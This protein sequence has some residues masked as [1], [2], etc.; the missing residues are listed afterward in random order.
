MS[1]FFVLTTL[2]TIERYCRR[3][4]SVSP[5]LRDLVR[6]S[7]AEL[8]ETVSSSVNLPVTTDSV[9]SVSRPTAGQM[10]N[11]VIPFKGNNSAMYSDI[12]EMEFTSD[13]NDSKRKRQL[14]D[15]DGFVHPGKNKTARAGQ[16]TTPKGPEIKLSNPFE[17]LRKET[18]QAGLSKQALPPQQPKSKRMPPIVVKLQKVTSACL[19]VIKGQASDLVTFEYNSNGLK[20]RTA[21]NADHNNIMNFLK[22]RGVEFYSLNPNPMQQVRFLLRGLPPRMENHEIIDGERS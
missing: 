7:R 11:P 2:R 22:N 18:C 14:P 13:A 8:L 21:T 3:P 20:V 17:P 6:I 4:R 5:R 9:C 12:E 19:I 16:L 10:S 15:E 1:E